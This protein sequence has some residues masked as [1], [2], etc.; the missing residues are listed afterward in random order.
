METGRAYSLALFIN[1]Q[2]RRLRPGVLEMR[3]QA[4]VI[5]ADQHR[6]LAQPHLKP[7]VYLDANLVRARLGQVSIDSESLGLLE[8]WAETGQSDVML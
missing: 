7:I 4:Y 5:L 2:S 6:H 8:A 3:H 1:Q